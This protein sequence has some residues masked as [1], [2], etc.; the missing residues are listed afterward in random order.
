MMVTN[1]M[2]IVAATGIGKSY[3]EQGFGQVD[4]VI[5]ELRPSFAPVRLVRS[6]AAAS[7]ELPL[8]WL[9]PERC[10][11]CGPSVSTIDVI[12]ISG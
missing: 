7:M 3:R 11:T 1:M 10:R 12:E 9:L 5:E 4:R 2:L 6:T 8:D